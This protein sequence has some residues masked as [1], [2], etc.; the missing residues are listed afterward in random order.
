MGIENSD[1]ELREAVAEL[2]QK[3]GHGE[4]DKRKDRPGDQP[5]PGPGTGPWIQDLVLE[6]L[7]VPYR[8]PLSA[9]FLADEVERRKAL[10]LARYGTLLQAFNGRD[11]LQDAM[12]EA[13]DLINYL[14]QALAEAAEGRDEVLRS[15]LAQAY[16]EALRAGMKL[17]WVKSLR[18]P[19]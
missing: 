9:A 6:D 19:S 17:A 7:R 4:P 3:T 13:V 12:E 8:Y 14:R 11:V 16:H 10:G 18:R 1:R 15:Q 2:R 5:M